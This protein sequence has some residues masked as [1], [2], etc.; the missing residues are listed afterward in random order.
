MVARIEEEDADERMARDP[1]YG[2]INVVKYDPKFRFILDRVT[3]ADA[4]EYSG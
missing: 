1:R 4:S 3:G 2:G